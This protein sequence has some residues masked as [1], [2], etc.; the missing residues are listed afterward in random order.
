MKFLKGFLY[1]FRGILYCINHE[2]NMRIHTVAT[3]YVLLF[4]PFFELSRG[5]YAL[6]LL[7]MAGVMSAEAVNTALERLTDLSSP[8]Y[9]PLARAAKDVAAGAVLIVA[10][11][12][13][14]VGVCLLWQ[15]AAFVRMFDFFTQKPWTLVLLAL[16]LPVVLLY[17]VKGPKGIWGMIKKQAR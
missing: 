3:L 13:V 14:L 2:R 5:Q 11:F 7:T 1:A 9:H 12:A 10:I 4:S 8:D 15:P 6:L 17:I 16:T